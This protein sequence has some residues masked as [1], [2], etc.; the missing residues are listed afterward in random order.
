MNIHSTDIVGWTF[1][2]S[3]FCDLCKPTPGN[4]EDKEEVNPIFADTPEEELLGSTCDA[5]QDCYTSDGWTE[6]DS[7]IRDYRWTRC[8]ECNT[9]TPY[10]KDARIRLSALRGKLE[11]LSCLRPTHF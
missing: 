10:P 7:A 11:C 1:D 3:I 5:C 2:G 8:P 4:S 9:Q 6:S